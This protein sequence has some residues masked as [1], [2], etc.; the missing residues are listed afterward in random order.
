MLKKLYRLKNER[1]FK[2]VARFGKKAQIDLLTL[3][4]LETRFE[5]SRFGIVISAKVLK[6]AVQRNYVKR[7]IIESVRLNLSQIKPGYDIVFLMYNKPA[8]IKEIDF[9]EK[10]LNLLK[11]AQLLK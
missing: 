8:N 10:T 4:Y 1:N 11:K 5:S 7:R 9:K 2:K 3:K 6:K